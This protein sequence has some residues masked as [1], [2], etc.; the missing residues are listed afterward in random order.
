MSNVFSNTSFVVLSV[1]ENY[2]GEGLMGATGF[3]QV[4][5]ESKYPD[6]M[7]VSFPAADFDAKDFQVQDR[8]NANV[9]S[10][11]QAQIDALPSNNDNFV[12]I[13]S[14]LSSKS[15]KMSAVEY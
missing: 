9:A 8:F 3:V 5:P 11:I 10:N 15:Y 4:L 12:T 7:T 13:K 2:V 6:I 1:M 14:N